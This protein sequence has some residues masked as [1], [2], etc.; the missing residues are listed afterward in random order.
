VPV[1]RPTGH[2]APSVVRESGKSRIR[3]PVA[4]KMAL[5]RQ[6]R[7]AARRV[8]LRRP[9]ERC[10]LGE[11]LFQSLNTRAFMTAVA[12]AAPE[13]VA[14]EHTFLAGFRAALRVAAGLAAVGIFAALVRGDEGR[15]P[16]Q[17]VTGAE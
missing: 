3:F 14:L 16:D 11:G 7:T 8:P 5:V 2:E 15:P 12:V 10:S 1:A 9:E 13:I 17:L 4:A 6:P